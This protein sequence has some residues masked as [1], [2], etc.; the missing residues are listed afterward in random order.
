MRTIIKEVEGIE[1]IMEILRT[2]ENEEE[3][4]PKHYKKTKKRKKSNREEELQRRIVRALEYL[5]S[6]N[7]GTHTSIDTIVNVTKSLLEG[8]GI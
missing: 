5:N 3:Y 2:L 4:K 6:D 8:Q 7:I 1:D